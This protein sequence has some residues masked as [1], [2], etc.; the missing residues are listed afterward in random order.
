M[1]PPPPPPLPPPPPP[2]AY[3]PTLSQSSAYSTPRTRR[4]LSAAGSAPAGCVPAG[5]DTH[6]DERCA[7]GSVE[8]RALLVPR[9]TRS[10]GE[11]EYWDQGEMGTRLLLAQFLLLHCA[12]ELGLKELD[13]PCN[14]RNLTVMRDDILHHVFSRRSTSPRTHVQHTVARTELERRNLHYH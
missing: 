9:R 6:H 7:G 5:P 11:R 10:A 8:L 14:F 3:H 4:T 1:F 2:D 12:R 13:R